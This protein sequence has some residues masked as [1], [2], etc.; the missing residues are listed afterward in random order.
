[1][2]KK[3]DNGSQMDDLVDTLK[4]NDGILDGIEKI[5]KIEDI[6]GL[7]K[8]ETPEDC[9]KGWESPV[10]LFG[11]LAGTAIGTELFGFSLPK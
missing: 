3:L 5:A 1:M 8:I 7:R 6:N 2:C 9:P 4:P 10:T 11:V